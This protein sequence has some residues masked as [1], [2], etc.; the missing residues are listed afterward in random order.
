MDGQTDVRYRVDEFV[1]D[2]TSLRITPFML[3]SY[4]HEYE[5]LVR[6][7]DAH[8]IEVDGLRSANRQL[9]AQV[10]VCPVHVTR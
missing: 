4:A 2:A 9:T 1:H 8:K 6:A 10:Y 5:E 3:D 7:R